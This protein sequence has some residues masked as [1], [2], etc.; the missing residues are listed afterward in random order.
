MLCVPCSGICTTEGETWQKHRDFFHQQMRHFVDEGGK[1]SQ[2]FIEVIMDEID[3]I[4][5]GSLYKDTYKVNDFMSYRKKFRF[6]RK[7]L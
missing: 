3:D 1:G 5:I 7:I 6:R 4:K 2:G